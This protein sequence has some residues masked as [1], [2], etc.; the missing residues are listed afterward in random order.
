VSSITASGNG[1]YAV[2]YGDTDGAPGPILGAT[3]YLAVGEHADVEIRLE[4]PLSSGRTTVWVIVHAEDGSN[5]TFE[6]P[7]GDPP[8]SGAGGAIAVP[9]EV[10]VG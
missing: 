9:I 5:E 2:A 4:R 7:E 10:D 1:G 3:E 6:F 8:V